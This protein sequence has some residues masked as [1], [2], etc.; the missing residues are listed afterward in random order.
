[1]LCSDPAMRTVESHPSITTG[2]YEKLTF[3]YRDVAPHLRFKADGAYTLYREKWFGEKY[4][5][6][7]DDAEIGQ[8]VHTAFGQVE[9][10]SNCMVQYTA[11]TST[12]S[13]AGNI[14][15]T[16]FDTIEKQTDLE[17]P[18]EIREY[19][20][21]FMKATD[22]ARM[23]TRFLI[24]TQMLIDLGQLTVKTTP[25]EKR[26]RCMEKVRQGASMVQGRFRA[27]KRV[28]MRNPANNSHHMGY[29][30]PLVSSLTNEIFLHGT[31]E[32][33]QNAVE[34]DTLEY[35]RRCDEIRER[36]KGMDCDNEFRHN[37][38]HLRFEVAGDP[39]RYGIGHEHKFKERGLPDGRWKPFKFYRK[40]AFGEGY[41]IHSRQEKIRSGEASGYEIQKK[42]ESCYGNNSRHTPHTTR[43]TF[44]E[45]EVH[46]KPPWQEW[47]GDRGGE[48]NSCTQAFHIGQ[49]T[50]PLLP[51]KRHNGYNGHQSEDDWCWVSYGTGYGGNDWYNNDY[52]RGYGNAE[53]RGCMYWDMCDLK[54][55][56]RTGDGLSATLGMLFHLNM[57]ENRQEML[58]V[59]RP[60]WNIRKNYGSQENF[61]NNYHT[62]GI[63]L[64]TVAMDALTAGNCYS[65]EDREWS[66]RR[67]IQHRHGSMASVYAR[68]GF[69]VQPQNLRCK[70]WKKRTELVEKDGIPANSPSTTTGLFWGKN[71]ELISEQEL[72]DLFYEEM[73]C[74]IHRLGWNWLVRSGAMKK[75]SHLFTKPRLTR[76]LTGDS[77]MLMKAYGKK[78]LKKTYADLL[79]PPCTC[80]MLDLDKLS[81]N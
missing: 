79:R 18:V 33:F 7:F 43:M 73:S 39:H 67:S 32:E 16:V 4:E 69:R 27:G 40:Q 64:P 15:R 57:I 8:F 58:K 44:E 54:Q 71:W 17:I 49:P 26:Y 48:T 65:V 63:M 50:T 70:Y 66:E 78:P 61:W 22:L 56:N 41:S 19:V 3:P 77:P 38:R 53:S 62:R 46:V 36:I 51:V 81:N 60:E 29:P 23:D 52:V 59:T 55:H 37:F 74:S 35:Y 31:D 13:P 25:P 72:E 2:I 14:L 21:S 34:K 20:C 75:Y 9:L 80:T 28:Q 47:Y 76:F 5:K 6:T 24:K 42:S 11:L 1:M 45:L 12:K 30:E 68:S 10:M